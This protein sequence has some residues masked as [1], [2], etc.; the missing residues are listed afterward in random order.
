MTVSEAP[1]AGPSWDL[2][3]HFRDLSDP[4]IAETIRRIKE[5]T[6]E[7]SR[8]TEFF[9]EGV[10]GSFAPTDSRESAMETGAR[11]EKCIALRDDAT[12]MLH[13]LS[14]FASCS[15]SVD[16]SLDAA[17]KILSEC[18]SLN[19]EL[20]VALKPLNLWLIRLDNQ[21]VEFL[22]QQEGLKNEEFAISHLRKLRDQAL[23]L[24]QE[25][26]LEKLDVHGPKGF[27][28]LYDDL[29]GAMQIHVQKGD[30]GPETVIGLA[31]AGNWMMSPD[32]K[33]RRATQEGINRAFK[34]QD[35]S[36]AAILN[37]ITGWRQTELRLRS[38]KRE[39][40][41][42]APPLHR[43]HIGRETL[44]AMMDAV[45]ANRHLG[46]KALKLQAQLLGKK[47]LDPWD[48]M[49][50]CPVAVDEKSLEIP[51]ADGVQI[52]EEA[53]GRLSP[54]MRDFVSMMVRNKWVD[55][56]VG[57][58][59][60][61]GA[62]C[63]QFFGKREP[64]VYMTYSGTL[65]NLSTLAHELGHA[66]H[67]WLMRDLPLSQLS[68]P[69]TLAETASIFAEALCED[70]LMERYR[71]EPQNLKAMLWA[72]AADA[73]VFL[74]NIPARFSMEWQFHEVKRKS[75]LTPEELCR[76]TDDAWSFWYGPSL[77][78][79]QSMFWA[80]KLHFSIPDLSFYNFPYTFGYLFS[81]SVFARREEFG[82]QFFERYTNLLRD[83]GRMTAEEVAKRHLGEDITKPKFW[84]SA[85]KI[86]ESRVNKFSLAMSDT[87]K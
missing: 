19:A 4:K 20:A 41:F 64:R 73:A 11:V 69:M 50:P 71:T 1:I 29:T 25:T 61:P 87:P 21:Q 52:L 58:K 86:V 74:L 9:A 27:G 26:M 31:E 43:A 37:H 30:E 67:F 47:V 7:L 80:T 38:T 68:Y 78:S 48:L 33:V 59:K 39:Q 57:P 63:T 79:P 10:G 6:L 51:F 72:S 60:M 45:S 62:Y 55:G 81:L 17:K 18:D 83:T 84:L 77:S 40:H 3:I 53:F 44:D 12:T 75:L 54:Q 34:A 15:M 32:E 56:S 2:S 42:L 14:T 70:Y 24:D 35:L 5:K 76:I 46:H 13:D 8:L 85:L 66:M 49:A 82:S 65:S 22:L 36:F 28:R 16:S 23:S